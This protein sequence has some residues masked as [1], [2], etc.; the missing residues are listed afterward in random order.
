MER[1]EF[2]VAKIEI[3]GFC[4]ARCDINIV[5]HFERGT[6]SRILSVQ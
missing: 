1:I 5:G 4:N 6:A 2:F 3:W